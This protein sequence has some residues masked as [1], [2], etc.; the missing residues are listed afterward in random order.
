MFHIIKLGGSL[1]DSGQLD[2]WL[3]IISDA[4]QPV[5]IV[6]GGGC[7]ADQIR[8]LQVRYQF[9]DAAAHHMAILSMQQFAHLIG[10]RAEWVRLL[11]ANSLSDFTLANSTDPILWMPTNLLGQQQH[12]APCWDTSSDA[13]ALWLAER[14]NTKALYFIKSTQLGIFSWD[15]V[16]H[17]N[18]DILDQETISKLSSLEFPYYCLE[19]TEQNFLKQSLLNATE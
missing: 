19:K 9:S 8:S 15:E 5:I 10:D 18:T 16:T 17:K 12:L 2:A 3:D 1:L 4:K 6:P 11:D 7:F 13:I 14:L